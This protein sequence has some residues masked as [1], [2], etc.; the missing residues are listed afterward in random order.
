VI[1]VLVIIGIAYFYS[2]STNRATGPSPSAP[3]PSSSPSVTSEPGGQ[4]GNKPSN[5]D[6]NQMTAPTA[7]EPSSPSQAAVS[8][9]TI[10][11]FAF[12]P[13]NLTIKKGDTVIWTNKDSA[14]HQVA[15]DDG[16]FQGPSLSKGQVYSF[17]F[18]ETGVFPYHC[19]VHP[20]MKA[21]ITVQ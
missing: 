13:A 18:N 15:S 17:T 3:P 1:I 6:Q 16:K 21:A 7:P 20:T 12:S 10:E 9:V 8:P 11:N 19:A 5:Q 14:P 2:K 4:P